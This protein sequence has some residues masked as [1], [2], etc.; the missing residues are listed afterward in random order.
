[1]DVDRPNKKLRLRSLS[2][3]G[4]KSRPSSE[5]VPGEGFKDPAQK[6]KVLKLARKSF[7]K[8]NKDARGGEADRVIRALKPKHL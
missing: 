6:S 5:L 4:S 3:S 7:K 1:M 2:R 8:R